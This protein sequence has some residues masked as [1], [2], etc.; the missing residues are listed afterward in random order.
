MS[1]P[2]EKKYAHAHRLDHTLEEACQYMCL[3]ASIN[4]G[5]LAATS[6]KDNPTQALAAL[7]RLLRERP[8]AF[9]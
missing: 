4:C 6:V 5:A 3:S 8:L 9:S 1:P 7:P 2:D